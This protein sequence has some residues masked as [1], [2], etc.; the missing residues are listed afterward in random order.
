MRFQIYLTIILL[1]RANHYLG[2]SND[3]FDSEFWIAVM[4]ASFALLVLL[5]RTK[6]EEASKK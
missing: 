4:F 6:E 5:P 1:M 2:L 3:F